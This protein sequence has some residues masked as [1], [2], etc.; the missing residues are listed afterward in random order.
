MRIKQI[1]KIKDGQDGVVFKNYLFRFNHLGECF[2]YDLNDIE[3]EAI[4]KFCL[5]K[6]EELMPHSNSVVFGKEYF[7]PD[8]EF[9]LLYT[10]IYNNYANAQD[11]LKGVCLVYRIQKNGTKFS[12]ALVQSIKIGFTEDGDYWKSKNTDDIRPYGNFT[13]DAEN[14]V[15]YAF[16]MRDE[17]KT[18]RYFAFDLPKLCDGKEVTLNICDIKEYF[19]CEYHRFVQGACFYNGKIYSL[20]GFTEDKENPPVMRIIDVKEKKQT[21]YIKFGDFGL[22]IEPEMIDFENDICYYA[23][24]HGNLY[25]I[26]F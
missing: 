12:S 1:A 5:D 25:V 3:N 20:E 16:T 13:I 19:D 23:D 17:S 14:G 26:D 4:D 15:Y 22:T 6:A 24:N 7:C 21:E 11:P 8:D 9:P 2:V 18:T 10:N